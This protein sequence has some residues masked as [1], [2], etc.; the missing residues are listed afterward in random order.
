MQLCNY[1]IMQVYASMHTYAIMQ[2]FNY[3]S[4]KVCKYAHICKYVHICKYASMRVCKYALICKYAQ[5]ICTYDVNVDQLIWNNLVKKYSFR[6]NSS[7]N[8]NRSLVSSWDFFNVE[9]VA[10]YR[11]Y[12][13][14]I[15]FYQFDIAEVT[16]DS[17]EVTKVVKIKYVR[18]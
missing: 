7:F 11:K 16:E 18:F 6:H 12:M 8:K 15:I 9:M 17:W 3:S 4:M 10:G 1:A 14:Y 13:L 2:I 5:G